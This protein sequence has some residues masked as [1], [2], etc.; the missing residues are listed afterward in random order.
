MLGSPRNG[1]DN[2][3]PKTYVDRVAKLSERLSHISHELD[4]GKE[5]KREVAE[6]ELKNLEKHW[7]ESTDSTNNKLNFLH[8]N[9]NKLMELIQEE[10][11]TRETMEE[12]S[13]RDLQKYHDRMLEQIQIAVRGRK[14]HYTRFLQAIDDKIIN[15][16]TE[17]NREVSYGEEGLVNMQSYVET[18]LPRVAEMSKGHLQE[19]D[20]LGEI[21]SK[22]LQEEVAKTNAVIQNEKK[23]RE[24]GEE[25]ILDLLKSFVAKL[26]KEMDEEKKQ[27][28]ANEEFLVNLLEE[29]CL[30]L[31]TAVRESL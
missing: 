13:H 5:I 22:N 6:N 8:E 9:C 18:Q 27:R 16:Q 26:E 7:N 1:F 2:R 17:V 14:E 25:K 31:N 28:E 20:R 3:E 12:G 24:E 30:K 11:E 15:A 19:A 29:T 21:L 4:N 23:A 10:R